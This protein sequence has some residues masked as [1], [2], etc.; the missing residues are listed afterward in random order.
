MRRAKAVEG[1]PDS[2]ARLTAV[3]GVKG[4]LDVVCVGE[5]LWDLYELDAKRLRRFVGGGSANVAVNLA[6]HGVRAAVVAAVGEDRFGD[7]LAET[8]EA[9]GVSTRFVVRLPERTALCF[10]ARS[11]DGQ[12]RYLNYRRGTADLGLRRGHVVPAMAR[13]RWLVFGSTAFLASGIAGASRA[14]LDHAE[15]HRAQV[16]LD[17][18]AR[19]MLWSS[20]AAALRALGP[21]LER[22]ALV[23]ASAFD[24]EALGL[25]EGALLRRVRPDAA[26]IVTRGA[27][28]ATC[29]TRG[30]EGVVEVAARPTGRAP[31]DASGAGDAFLA[32]VL[33]TRLGGG[34]WTRALV[35]GHRL[36]ARVVQS[37]G[38]VSWRRIPGQPA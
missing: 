36:G 4:A 21:A 26:V 37:L 18:N 15:R 1:V 13:A 17:V 11:A 8:L 24:L 38:A 32:G 9:E 25:A 33:A 23:K 22:A 27:G 30:A 28:K 35:V 2:R 5:A 20:R 6:R 12:P 29:W 31:I 14:L 16:A 19:P 7:L 10:V 34:N 3:E